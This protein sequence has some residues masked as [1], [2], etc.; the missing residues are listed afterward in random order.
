MLSN[1]ILLITAILGFL[2]TAFIYGKHIQQEHSLINRYLIVITALVAVRFL[3][4]GIAEANPT[5]NIRRIITILDISM[6]IT[7]PCTYLYFQNIVYENKFKMSNLLHFIVPFLLGA[8][9]ISTVFLS[10]DQIAISK[11]IFFFT[12]IFYCFTYASL[13][14]KL[15]YQN[16]WRRKSDIKA[17]QQQN[18]IIK[19]WSIFLYVCFIAIALIR[20]LT[21]I[22]SNKPGNFNNSYLWIPAL[23][24]ISIFVKIILTPEILY[25][26]NF[27]NKTIETATEKV[28]LN[29]VWKIAG[30]V[31]PIASEKDKKLAEKMATL[32]TGYVHKIEELSFHSVVFRN[33]ELSVEDIAVSLNIPLSNINFIFKYHCNESF[34]DYK[35]IIRIHDATKLLEGGYLN[36]S[37]VE[38]L[39]TV[40]GFSSY[41]TFNI[42]FKSIT[43]VT[44]QD[45]V[46]RL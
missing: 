43:G 12:F 46:K 19:S 18:E 9:F 35:K 28:A 21:A 14:F 40:V 20:I 24:W 1:L 41:N 3:V 32:L 2:C 7:M 11:K 22:A 4:Y 23:I 36:N 6:A 34:T 16:I 31:L 5:I 17:I 30:T 38:S 25:G 13:T 39:S 29:S 33:P 44:T 10:S 26:Y 15:L 37:T 42:A 27:L 8:V 45:Y